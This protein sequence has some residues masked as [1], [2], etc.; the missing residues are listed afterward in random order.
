MNVPPEPR[1]KK[2]QQPSYKRKRQRKRQQ[3]MLPAAGLATLLAVTGCA[4]PGVDSDDVTLKFAEGFSASHPIAANGSMY[5]LDRLREEGPDVGISVEFYPSSQLGSFE[6]VPTMLSSGIADISDVVP[7]YLSAQLPLSSAF[8]LPGYTTDSCVGAAAVSRSVAE[9]STAREQEIEQLGVRPLWSVLLT[10]YE[11][12]TSEPTTD[13]HGR[14][15]AI[16]RSPGGAVDRVVDAMGAAG[17]SMPL[18]DMYEAASRGTVDGTVASPTSMAPYK[19]A[20][21]LPNSTIGAELGSVAVLY[22]ISEQQWSELNDEQRVV[23]TEAAEA[24]EQN[25]CAKL[26]ELLPEAQ[27]QMEKDGTTLHRLTPDQ[28]SE[29]AQKVSMPARENWRS[30]L[31]DMGLPAEAVLE[32]WEAALRKEESADE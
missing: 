14:Q 2:P 12:M 13:P 8:D 10:G 24:T 7:A 6:D 26:N 32:E 15:G 11:L 31:T 25:L 27:D 23:V 29:W 18:G 17:V 4:G 5:F 22:S 16:L 21:V 30:D 28:K 1:N 3:W 19:L 9:G 20:E